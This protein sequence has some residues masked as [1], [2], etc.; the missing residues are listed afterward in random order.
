MKKSI[1]EL[2]LDVLSDGQ[3]HPN[4]EIAELIKNK[5][6]IWVDSC[7]ISARER[8]VLKG[9]LEAKRGL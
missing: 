3:Y 8:D 9:K 7:T 2:I 6:G 4:G 5:Y 1:P